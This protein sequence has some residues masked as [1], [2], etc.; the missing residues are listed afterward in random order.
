MLYFNL[1]YL[2][3]TQM[4][5]NLI[6]DNYFKVVIFLPDLLDVFVEDGQLPA[7]RF[8]FSSSFKTTIVLAGS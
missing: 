1:K 6:R 8:V 3:F 2:F 4:H 5:Q 7:I